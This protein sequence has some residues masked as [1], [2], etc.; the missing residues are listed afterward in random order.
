VNLRRVRLQ[1]AVLF[2]GLV[3]VAV[4]IFAVLADR[5][6]SAR[7]RERAERELEQ[8][9]GE[10]LLVP[11]LWNSRTGVPNVW[12]VNPD[13]SYSAPV[14]DNIWVEPPLLT[15]AG[16]TYE[17]A[18]VFRRFD[19][20]GPWLAY[21]VFVGPSDR[22]VIAQEYGPV[23]DEIS[24]QRWRLGLLALSLIGAAGALA[25]KLAG[26][27]L[28]PARTA[29]GQQRDFI[30]DAAHELRTPLAVIQA[31]ATQTLSRPREPWEYERSLHE[32]QMAAE[33]AGHG[34]ATL[35]DLARLEAGQAVPRL[36][37]LRVDLLVEEVAAATKVD[38]VE[39]GVGSTEALIVN[40]DYALLRQA[41]ANLVENAAARSGRV[42]VSAVRDEPN[43]RI[44]VTDDGPGFDPELLPH[45]FTRFRRGDQR[46]TAGIGMA[47]VKTIVD[48]HHGT[49]VATNRVPSTNGS[50]PVAGDQAA[51]SEASGSEPLAAG[52]TAAPAPAGAEVTIRLPIAAGP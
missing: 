46:G 26:R 51:A 31:S 4:L 38:G 44:T 16:E 9:M 49:C 15:I 43:A 33:R 13:E 18:P 12:I 11:D 52:Q 10:L 25:W 47:I 14:T 42:T 35:L 50:D 6:G 21:A 37:P 23:Q 20:N 5:A 34:V 3:A 41:L 24:G 2:T 40:A 19:Q 8:T 32:I 27:S 39:I 28:A 1:L 22:Y 30:A 48:V 7:S 45:V 17:G 36:A 29:M